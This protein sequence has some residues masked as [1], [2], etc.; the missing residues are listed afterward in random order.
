M[1]KIDLSN[2]TLVSSLLISVVIAVLYQF[3]IVDG[4]MLKIAQ[5]LLMIIPCGYICAKCAEKCVKTYCSYKYY[6]DEYSKQESSPD[7][8]FDEK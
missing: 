6:Y 7:Y 5:R 4:Y 3:G 2:F 1:K 8:E